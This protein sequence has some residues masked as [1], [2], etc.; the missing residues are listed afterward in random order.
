MSA[1]QT[2][3]YAFEVPIKDSLAWNAMI[4]GIYPWTLEDGTRTVL[5]LKNTTDQTVHA[6][7]TISFRGG[8]YNFPLLSFE[9]YQTIG[10][11]I[12][13][14]K[15]SKKPDA[16]GIPFPA[17]ATHGQIVWF[18]ETPYTLVGRAEQTN[19][20]EGIARSFS[21]SDICCQNYNGYVCATSN[22][23]QGCSPMLP[24]LNPGA[25]PIATAGLTGPLGGSGTL[26]AYQ[27]NVDC[28]NNNFG[29]SA[30]TPYSWF[31]NPA[32]GVASVS[33]GT[34]NYT[35]TGTTNVGLYAYIY[36]YNWTS[37][38][39]CLGE[40][41]LNGSTAADEPQVT[42]RVPHHLLV[43]SDVFTS[44]AM[45]TGN[46]QER[47]IT[48]E[49]VDVAGN[50]ISNV[51]VQESFSNVS[52]NTCPNPSIPNASF[53]QSTDVNGEFTDG[54]HNNCS[55]AGSTCGYS[56]T[57]EWQWC[58]SSGPVNLGKL[59]DVVQGTGVTVN[60]NVS[61]FPPATPIFP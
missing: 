45:C 21:C 56:L 13:A 36:D 31:T 43:V 26:G 12:Q 9:P 5:H 41:T 3:D 40:T 22:T 29:P 11:D 25:S 18:P 39:Q 60:G 37:H 27:Y 7:T 14:L 35:A 53:C 23:A 38:C 55:S 54:I 34:V 16:R 44:D 50:F 20:S 17:D 24:P 15:D 30:V 6:W 59:N 42:V 48:F 57:D 33:G 10:I 4:E 2:G 52:A 49:V 58:P 28:N 61:G 1:N 46:V 19:L 8:T 47:D 32:N 51:P